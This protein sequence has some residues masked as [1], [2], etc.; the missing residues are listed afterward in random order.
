MPL[1]D[2]QDLAIH[3]RTEQGQVI[4]A[5]DGVS[6]HVDRGEVLCLVGESGSG[7]TVTSLS[8]L[9]L[10]PSPPARIV[11]G[12]VLYQDSRGGAAIDLAQ[13]PEPA[14]RRIRG[15]RIA[16]VFQDPMTSLNPYLTV[17]SQLSE[18]LEVHRGTSGAAAREAV[19]RVLHDVGLPAPAGRLR[20]YPHQLSGGMRQRVM[21]AMALLCEPDLLIAD[22]PTTAL[23]VTV[24][25]QILRLV[26]E[27]KAALGLG[28]L[29]IT[30]D[31]GVVARLADRV[32]V[33]QSGRIVEHGP[34]EQML[35]APQHPY[36]A[37]LLR[38]VP[39]LDVARAEA[40]S[41]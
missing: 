8:L 35:R 13:A 18:V 41:P 37:A 29:W 32:A 6:F 15:N 16:M 39:R 24:Q 2:V 27:R 31:F 34:V 12:R 33:M 26:A 23:D 3:F 10:L 1:L 19:V 40:E 14:L 38:A 7:K 5:V 30:H 25:A 17:G 21:I 11:G 20:D 9:R 36:T 22:E 28:V 4:R